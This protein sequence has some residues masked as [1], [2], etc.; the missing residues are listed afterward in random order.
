M[1]NN[2]LEYDEEVF[3]SMK[4]KMENDWKTDPINE[5][6]LDQHFSGFFLKQ[7]ENFTQNSLLIWSLQFQNQCKKI[8]SPFIVPY[9]RQRNYNLALSFDKFIEDQNIEKF[10]NFFTDPIMTYYFWNITFPNIFGSFFS[11]EFCKDALTFL[12]KFI[13][14]KDIYSVG[15]ISFINHNILFQS[16]LLN[17]FYTLLNQQCTDKNDSDVSFYKWCQYDQDQIENIFQIALTEALQQLDSHQI[18]ALNTLFDKYPQKAKEHI[19][20]DIILYNLKYVWPYSSYFLP[21]AMLDSITENYTNNNQPL[22]DRIAFLDKIIP[23]AKGLTS[24]ADCHLSYFVSSPAFINVTNLDLIFIYSLCSKNIFSRYPNIHSDS[25]QLK[26]KSGQELIEFMLSRSFKY[27]RIEYTIIHSIQ[28]K[29]IPKIKDQEIENEWMKHEEQCKH[30]NE[31]PLAVIFNDQPI[32]KKLAY[33]GLHKAY[34]KRINLQ[35]YKDKMANKLGCLIPIQTAMKMQDSMIE[36]STIGLSKLIPFDSIPG[37]LQNLYAN[38]VKNYLFAFVKEN[39]EVKSES[40][41]LFDKVYEKVFNDQI[42]VELTSKIENIKDFAIGKKASSFLFE[43][44]SSFFTMVQEKFVDSLPEDKKNKATFYKGLSI[45]STLD[46]KSFEY[47]FCFIRKIE[48]PLI[49]G[50]FLN[51]PQKFSDEPDNTFLDGL[52][53]SEYQRIFDT[54][55]SFGVFSYIESVCYNLFKEFKSDEEKSEVNFGKLFVS[56]P[57]ILEMVDQFFYKQNNCVKIHPYI[58]PSFMDFED[59]T[60]Q[61]H[62]FVQ[63]IFKYANSNKNMTV[64]SDL[65]KQYDEGLINAIDFYV[66]LVNSAYDF[67]E[68]CGFRESFA[69]I[70]K[71]FDEIEQMKLIFV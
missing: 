65:I 68:N 14:S 60:A 20:S 45:R 35:E 70:Q 29:S 28:L 39:L 67:F 38:Y 15:V 46:S 62:E 9:L 21:N 7:Y 33:Y 55:D 43:L 36:M 37:S 71:I 34:H 31:H 5:E 11:S 69:S 41:E 19:F 48:Y 56:I 6:E 3:L 58:K 25:E 44:Y 63:L 30:R 2:N 32:D 59:K 47:A 23:I 61:N 52:D 24:K 66:K 8:G 27:H 17:V 42:Q 1:A 49:V 26:Q 22:E 53:F 40:D 64:Y 54:L 16:T 10:T 4:E 12:T 13:N 57:T 51:A 50:Y 18:E